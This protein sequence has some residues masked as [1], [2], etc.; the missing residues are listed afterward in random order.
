[1]S[2]KATRAVISG[3]VI[4]TALISLLYVTVSEGAQYYKHVDEVMNDPSPWYGKSMQLHGFVV[5]KSIERRPDSLQRQ[6]APAIRQA[7]VRHGRIGCI[8]CRNLRIVPWMGSAASST[9]KDGDS[10]GE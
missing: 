10:P 1:M 6:E 3:V 8:K 2:K 9:M 4:L 7:S 5:D